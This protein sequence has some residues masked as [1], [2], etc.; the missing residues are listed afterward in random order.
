MNNICFETDYPHSDSTRP[1]SREIAMKLMGDL[2]PDVF[3]KLVRGNA[4]DLLGLD[5]PR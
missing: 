2:P 1:H 5:L 3:S 4:I